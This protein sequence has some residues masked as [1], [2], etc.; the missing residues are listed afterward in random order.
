MAT[1]QVTRPKGPSWLHSLV[2]SSRCRSYPSRSDQRGMS[3]TPIFCYSFDD[4]LLLP[5]PLQTVPTIRFGSNLFSSKYSAHVVLIVESPRFLFENEPC[6]SSNQPR[7]QEQEQNVPRVE[8]V[9]RGWQQRLLANIRHNNFIRPFRWTVEMSDASL[10]NE[11]FELHSD[12]AKFEMSSNNLTITLENSEIKSLVPLTV[13][14][15]NTSNTFHPCL[16]VSYFQFHLNRALNEQMYIFR[17]QIHIQ[18]TPLLHVSVVSVYRDFKHLITTWKGS[19]RSQTPS[20]SPMHQSNSRSI[21]ISLQGQIQL[22]FLLSNE[23]QSMHC[24]ASNINFS[25]PSR[26]R[27]NFESDLV[28]L[29][30]DERH[31]AN[32]EV[33]NRLFTTLL[34]Y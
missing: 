2:L 21:E 27:A 24:T 10:R 11:F 12:S 25:M 3:L 32:F 34:A 29:F 18:W 8:E 22:G 33:S 4:S 30:C 7:R 28:S 1:E 23:G 31:I 9:V 13:D 19:G 5:F 20:N 15:V 6:I 17:D 16:E 26:N 14:E